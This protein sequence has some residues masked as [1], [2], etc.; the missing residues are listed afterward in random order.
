MSDQEQKLENLQV[1]RV[2]EGLV[3][4]NLIRPVMDTKITT[5]EEGKGFV[6][7][8]LVHLPTPVEPTAQPPVKPPTAEVVVPLTTPAPTQEKPHESK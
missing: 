2:E 6:P 1:G 8:L 3:G 5:P 4:P 7:P